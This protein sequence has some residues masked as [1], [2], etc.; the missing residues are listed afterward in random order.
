M[1]AIAQETLL[2][3]IT[4]IF[5]TV[6]EAAGQRLLTLRT[7]VAGNVKRR[8][9]V[10]EELLVGRDRR[11]AFSTSTPKRQVRAKKQ[12]SSLVTSF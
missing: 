6:V 4:G 9:T 11:R 12:C 1:T 5:R 8:I 7:G 2:R 3:L 10:V